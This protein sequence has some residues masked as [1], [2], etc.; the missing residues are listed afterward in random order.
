M[1]CHAQGGV[2][3]GD[4]HLGGLSE[5]FRALDD[6]HAIP[7]GAEMMITRNKREKEDKTRRKRQAKEQEIIDMIED[8]LA[9][10][11]TVKGMYHP[12]YV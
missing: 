4:V 6:F 7:E 1:H 5:F 2:G 3:G 9:N 8:I 12:A 10:D 11:L